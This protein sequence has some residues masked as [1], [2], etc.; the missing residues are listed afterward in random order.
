MDQETGIEAAMENAQLEALDEELYNEVSGG[1][2]LSD[3]AAEVP[4]RYEARSRDK[5]AAT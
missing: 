2:F 4:H 1:I 3:I 5:R